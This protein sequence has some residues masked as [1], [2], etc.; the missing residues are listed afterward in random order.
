[1]VAREHKV[2]VLPVGPRSSSEMRGK[3]TLYSVPGG[4]GQLSERKQKVVGTYEVRD[5]L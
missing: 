2:L 5:L 4:R 1:M 3:S